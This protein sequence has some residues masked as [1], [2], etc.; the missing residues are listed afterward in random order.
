MINLS[1]PSK[2]YDENGQKSPEHSTPL[3]MQITI[4][5]AL[6][7]EAKMTLGSFSLE[8]ID[9]K[10]VSELSI[11]IEE[12]NKIIWMKLQQMKYTTSGE[13]RDDFDDQQ[14][15]SSPACKN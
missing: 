5:A 8:W 6:I 11:L 3:T 2:S 12:F 13:C 14:P 9:F 1:P 4:G 10:N 7:I 15:H